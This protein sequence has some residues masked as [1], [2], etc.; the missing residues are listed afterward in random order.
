MLEFLWEAKMV[1]YR[2]RGHKIVGD[3]VVDISVFLFSLEEKLRN[4]TYDAKHWVHELISVNFLREIKVFLNDFNVNKLGDVN[5]GVGF[6]KQLHSTFKTTID[7]LIRKY[8]MAQPVNDEVEFV[9]RK[10][11]VSTV[12][13]AVH[14]NYF[15]GK[16]AVLPQPKT[17]PHAALL[18]AHTII[19]KTEEAAAAAEFNLLLKDPKIAT[20]IKRTSEG[21]IVFVEKINDGNVFCFRVSGDN[22]HAKFMKLYKEREAE[23]LAQSTPSKSLSPSPT[24]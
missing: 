1:L 21:K 10:L 16:S 2:F 13:T 23:K 9:W 18:P 8:P 12:P 4:K 14:P 17:E 3:P 7:P 22:I 15:G 5:Y 19:G 20:C 24:A 6:L 11:P